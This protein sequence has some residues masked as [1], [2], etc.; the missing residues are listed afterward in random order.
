MTVGA[1]A[2]A[3]QHFT[4]YRALGCAGA[5]AVEPQPVHFT[6]RRCVEMD[7]EATD[8]GQHFS[9]D[10]K[11]SGGEKSN[12]SPEKL[13]V[14]PCLIGEREVPTTCFPISNLHLRIIAFL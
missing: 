13:L 6:Q 2:A 3:L 11:P 10:R 4:D 5:A 14:P 12:Q 7:T 8:G 9:K 1:A